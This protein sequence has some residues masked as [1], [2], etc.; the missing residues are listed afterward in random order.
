MN[1]GQKPHLNHNHDFIVAVRKDRSLE[2]F[3][4]MGLVVNKSCSNQLSVCNI[5]V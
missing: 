5:V 1:R 4:M 3:D 2:L